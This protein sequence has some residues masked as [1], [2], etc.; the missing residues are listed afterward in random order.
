LSN[1]ALTLL[2]LDEIMVFNILVKNTDY[3]RNHAAFWV[4][5]TKKP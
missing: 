5:E 3:A 2:V 1:P 4:Y